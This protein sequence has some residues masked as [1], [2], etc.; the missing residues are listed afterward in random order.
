VLTNRPAERHGG[1]R[2]FARNGAAMILSALTFTSAYAG[3]MLNLSCVGSGR[4][5][6]NCVALWG[7]AGDPNVRPVPP[8]SV[9]D[10]DRERDAAADRKWRARCHP[11]VEPDTYGVLR[12]HYAAPGCEFGVGAN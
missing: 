10:A 8:Q 9:S 11:H 5:S 3:N 6:V 2:S 4:T 12:Y 7:A 1:N